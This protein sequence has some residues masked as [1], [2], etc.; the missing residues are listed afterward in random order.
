MEQYP[1]SALV[2]KQE[3]TVS[4]LKLQGV[5][6]VFVKGKYMI[7]NEN[8]DTSSKEAYAKEYAELVGFLLK[9]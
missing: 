5:P 1:V 6:A 7:K 9:K 3:R 4:D 2:D 8:I